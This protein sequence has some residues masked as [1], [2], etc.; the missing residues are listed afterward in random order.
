MI[1]YLFSEP[2]LFFFAADMPALLYYSHLP[3]MVLALLVGLF[4]FINGRQ[5]LLNRLLLVISVSFSLW[6]LAN[7]I[8]WTNIHSDFILLVWSFFGLLSAIISLSCVYLIYAFLT[9]KDVSLRIKAIFLALLAPV[10]VLA[11]TP[12][13]LSGFNITHCD[14]FG[15]EN[16]P[17]EIYYTFLGVLAMVW[18]L[19]LLIRGYQSASE[20]MKKQVVLMGIGIEFF[21]F[22]FFTM[23]FLASYLTKLG[24]L[25][26]SQIEMYGLF[27]M[28]VFMVYVGILIV[29][30]HTFHVGLIAAQALIISLLLLMTTQ[31]TFV[32]SLTN[33]VLTL[34]AI[35][36]TMGIGI[37]LIRSVKREIEQRKYIEKLAVDLETA[38]ARLK[39][40]DQL[41]SEFLSVASHQLRAPI[42]AVRGYVAN[43]VDG[44]Y[45]EVPSYLK[46]PLRVIQESARLMVNS[47]ED[48]LNISRI[49]QGRMKYEKSEFD[50]SDLSHKVVNEL[51]PVATAKNL[52]L[53]FST[54][55]PMKVIADIGKVKQ[56]IT[57][58]IDNGI[59]YTELGS[60]TVA[61]AKKESAIRVTIS[62]TGVGIAPEDIDKLFSKFTRTRDANKV[63]TTGT[64]LGL[65]VAKKLTEGNGGKIWVESDGIG[66]GSRFIIELP[67]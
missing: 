48:Y 28:V 2:K 52:K 25:P 32:R 8:A 39:Q 62:D 50:I 61:V 10:M 15:F 14:A 27:G 45:G 37:F 16:L 22:S 66:K 12:F 31:L 57:N 36:V 40:L 35:F 38:N 26:D 9:G 4:V 55:G 20:A 34:I 13:A 24:I 23:G 60:V 1:C 53:L 5:F 30:Y 17:F 67:A 56:V 59:K 6:T 21:L 65:Y 11:P 18:I 33:V 63:N 42:T 49:E 44:S 41:K 3:A 29:R 51:E 7:L 54:E 19:V 58:L 64:G 43:M 47:I 46:D